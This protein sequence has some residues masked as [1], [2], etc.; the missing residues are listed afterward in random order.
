MPTTAGSSNDSGWPSIAASASMPP[1]PQP[2]TPRPLTIGVCE[3]V[4][5][6]V[7]GYAR[8]SAVAEHDLREELEVDL[9]ADALARWE[10]AQRAG[11]RPAPIA[12]TCSAP[13]CARTRS[14]CCARTR[15]ERRRRRRRSSGRSRGRPGSRGSTR[16][17]RPPRS[18]TASRIAARSTIAGTPVKSCIKTRAGMN[19]ELARPDLGGGAAAIGER[20]DVV[21][22]RRSRRPRG[23]TG[24]RAGCAANT[25]AGGDRR[26]TRRGGGCRNVL[27]AD[28]EIRPRPERV[29]RHAR[30]LPRKKPSLR[31]RRVEAEPA[32]R[33][34]Y[35]GARSATSAR[36]RR[37]AA[38]SSTAPR[39]AANDPPRA[40]HARRRHARPRHG[41]PRFPRL[42]RHQPADPGEATLRCARRTVLPRPR[43]V[44]DGCTRVLEVAGVV[45]LFTIE[46]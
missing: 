16:S 36:R 39:A 24:S 38:S 37:S 41:R 10:H 5:T 2:S 17:A 8:P 12:G 46:S 28:D 20:G 34:S 32:L 29:E 25:G 3:S 9:V 23:A 22:A 35:V 21:G 15:R 14:R 31:S 45:E 44:A 26:P 43:A 1:T 18:T 6:S 42:D 11:T 7:S 19:V 40:L 30:T 13:R 4:P 27:V 33:L